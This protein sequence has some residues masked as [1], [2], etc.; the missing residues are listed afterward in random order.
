MPRFFAIIPAAGQSTRMGRP[1]LLLPVGGKPLIVRTIEAWRRSK[2]EAIVVVLRAGDKE[3]AEVVH[4]AG[5]E[6]V[7]A[8]EPPPDMKV[9]VREGLTYINAR[10]PSSGRARAFLVAPAD[11]P[12]LSS[13]IIDRL[14]TMYAN[15]PASEQQILVPTIGGRRGHPVLFPMALAEGVYKLPDSAGLDA[16][17]REY[18][19]TLVDCSDLVSPGGNPF[20]DIDTPEQYGRLCGE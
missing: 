10:H 4:A 6:V 20:A 15:F 2:I 5:A 17:I 13:A 9:S 16:L 18:G 7:A 3:L 19:A 11:M 8:H 1:K 12:G 14:L